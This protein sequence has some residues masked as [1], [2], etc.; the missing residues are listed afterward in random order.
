MLAGHTDRVAWAE[1][2]GAWIAS[3]KSL[4][5]SFAAFRERYLGEKGAEPSLWEPLPARVAGLEAG[6]ERLQKRRGAEE[7]EMPVG[8]FCGGRRRRV[9]PERRAPR[10]NSTAGQPKPRKVLEP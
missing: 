7:E 10:A 2:V 9:A 3:D 1:L 8:C 4:G 6:L 5:E